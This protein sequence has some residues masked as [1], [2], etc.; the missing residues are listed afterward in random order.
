MSAKLHFLH[1]TKR[2]KKEIVSPWWNP[3]GVVSHAVNGMKSPLRAKSFHHLACDLIILQQLN[4]CLVLETTKWNASLLGLFSRWFYFNLND[5][6][7][8]EI[9]QWH[10]TLRL[11]LKK[12]FLSNCI[13][14]GMTTVVS[15]S[16]YAEDHTVAFKE[17]LFFFFYF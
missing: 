14:F 9:V 13:R 7:V 12:I 10:C 1:E 17:L 16:M 11:A 3:A 2:R 15:A 5:V 6:L 8:C 4:V